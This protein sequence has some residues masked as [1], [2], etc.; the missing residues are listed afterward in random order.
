MQKISANYLNKKMPPI[1]ELNHDQSQQ[2][3]YSYRD[4]FYLLLSFFK[5]EFKKKDGVV[6]LAVASRRDG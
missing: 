3:W 6:H 1:H 2:Q 4:R 5:L